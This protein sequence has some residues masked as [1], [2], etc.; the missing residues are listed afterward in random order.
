MLRIPD[1][2][3][4]KLYRDSEAS[5]L[6]PSS[7]GTGDV[8]AIVASPTGAGRWLQLGKKGPGGRARDFHFFRMDF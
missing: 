3:T 8:H 5:V 6:A 4:K 7:Q 2:T 1:K